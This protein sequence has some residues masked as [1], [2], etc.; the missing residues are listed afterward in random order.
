M[1]KI[2]ISK[3]TGF[4]YGGSGTRFWMLRLGINQRIAD[5]LVEKEISPGVVRTGLKDGF[6]LPFYAWECISIHTQ[7]REIDLV[8]QNEYQMK[9]FIQFLII[10]LD[11]MN[12]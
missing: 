4:I 12:G 7:E 6:E 2:E 5:N 9:A 1:N 3:I 10:R 11:S 8:I